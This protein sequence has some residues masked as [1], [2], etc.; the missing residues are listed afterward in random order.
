MANIKNFGLSGIGSYVQF[1]K[2]GG[3]LVYDS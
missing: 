1:G 2:S 3:R